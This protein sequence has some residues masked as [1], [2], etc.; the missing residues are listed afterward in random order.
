MSSARLAWFLAAA[1][2]VPVLSAAEPKEAPLSQVKADVEA[3]KAILVDVR[4][5]REWDAGHV[6]GAIFLPLRDIAD[7][8]TKEEAAKLPREKIV[9]LHCAIGLRA[10][11]AGELLEEQGYQV[12][13]LDVDWNALVKAGF[14]KAKD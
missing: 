6:E 11:S 13:P 8:L 14:A 10:A 7:G 1:C 9:Y 4:E 3:G 2:V 12:R 5:K